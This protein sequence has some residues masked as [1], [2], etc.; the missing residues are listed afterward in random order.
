MHLVLEVEQKLLA[1]LDRD[2]AFDLIDVEQEVRGQGTCQL[3]QQKVEVDGV[4]LFFE[5]ADPCLH[6]SADIFHVLLALDR[7]LHLEVSPVHL[8]E[9]LTVNLIVA[10]AKRCDQAVDAL[11]DQF[12]ENLT[13]LRR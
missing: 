13:S 12:P 2:R 8:K 9:G 3:I 11:S 1:G 7:T 6:F 4:Q 10:C 5:C